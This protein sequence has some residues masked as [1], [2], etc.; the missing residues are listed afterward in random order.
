M[1]EV[2][3]PVLE[4][5]VFR[6]EVRRGDVGVAR[7]PA[8]NIQGDDAPPDRGGR[9][10]WRRRR[11]RRWRTLPLACRDLEDDRAGRGGGVRW[12]ARVA[13]P[14]AD[15]VPAGDG[16]GA[17]R[18]RRGGRVGAQRI[19]VRVESLASAVVGGRPC[20]DGPGGPAKSGRRKVAKLECQCCFAEHDFEDMVSCRLGGHLFCPM[21]TEGQRPRRTPPPPALSGNRRRRQ[22]RHLR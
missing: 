19:R 7:D 18:D 8:R 11:R 2:V 6:D 4:R 5:P 10:R 21:T 20:G 12:A 17:M 9:R 1:R 14:P 3:S 15:A 13:V 16:V 22:L